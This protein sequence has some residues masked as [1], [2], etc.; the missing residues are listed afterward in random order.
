MLAWWARG[1]AE[2]RA[3]AERPFLARCSRR[4]WRSSAAPL[5]CRQRS[6]PPRPHPCK[7]TLHTGRAVEA[8]RG[9]GSAPAHAPLPPRSPQRPPMALA[10]LV[11]RRRA[12]GRR[13]GAAASRLMI[14][15]R[16]S[17]PPSA[18]G[19]RPATV[20]GA[21]RVRT[22]SRRRRAAAAP[23]GAGVDAAAPLR[24]CSYSM[25]HLSHCAQLA[26]GAGVAA[27]S[28]GRP[29]RSLVAAAAAA[30]L[31]HGRAALLGALRLA[32]QL[33]CWARCSPWAASGRAGRRWGAARRA[34]CAAARALLPTHRTSFLPS[35][36][37]PQRRRRRA[38][39]P[40]SPMHLRAACARRADALRW[41][42]KRARMLWPRVSGGGARSPGG[43]AAMVPT[44]S[45]P[46]S[47]VGRAH[48]CPKPA[49]AAAT[50]EPAPPLLR[51]LLGF[52]CRAGVAA[53]PL[54]RIH[55]PLP[56]PGGGSPAGCAL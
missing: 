4:R 35:F 6:A 12:R 42:S 26:R 49:P 36:H 10:A 25:Q 14:S 55:H 7:L 48:V 20:V 45:P 13:F 32:V 5:P 51:P 54:P 53:S 11:G 44:P 18:G 31:L 27:L 22:L 16:C 40:P 17:W 33:P 34:R 41:P 23:P 19:A 47:P 39:P 52:W 37:P 29:E 43:V 1:R 30:A 38:F 28:D 2:V 21:G 50:G 24:P 8:G 46:P 9:G 56:A 3:C 15:H